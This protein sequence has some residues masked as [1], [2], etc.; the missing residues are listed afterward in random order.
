[1]RDGRIELPI[2]THRFGLDE[3]QDAYDVFSRPDTTGA[4]KVVLFGEESILRSGA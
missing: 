4:L 2:V 1:M 3:M